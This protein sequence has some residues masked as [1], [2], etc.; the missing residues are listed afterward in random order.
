MPKIKFDI[1]IPIF[2]GAVPN[3]SY[4]EYSKIK[5][6]CKV[7][8]EFGY[9]T[10]W[11]ADHLTMGEDHRIWE[12]WTILSSLVNVTNL[13]LGTAML[14]VVHRNPALL[15][16]MAATFD[17][18]TEGR[19][20]FGLGAG[21]RESEVREYGIPWSKSPKE[22]VEMLEE[23]L[24]IAK[25]MWTKDAPSFHG[26]H[27][28]IEHAWCEPKPIQKPHPPIWIGG[29]GEKLLLKLVARHADGWDIPATTTQV[30]AHKAK[31]LEQYCREEQRDF[32]RIER[33]IDTNIII[34]DDPDIGRKVA[35]WYDWLRHVQSEIGSL[36]PPLNVE[37]VFI[38]G[39]VEK[40]VRRIEEYVNAGVE[41]F[42]FYFFDYP[43]LYSAKRIGKEV[44]PSFS[45]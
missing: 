13:R 42:K 22:R 44:I 30:Y 28:S 1:T 18:I 31:L 36:K 21:W 2:A 39:S 8:E 34:S 45:R 12:C 33:S 19:L 15:A 43:D 32:A 4:L 10:L 5:E 14:N 6:L 20:N 40:C 38:F 29:G 35:E 27:F 41:R 24:T 16:K 9:D 11:V 25:L 7:G 37:D 17:L 26:K 23:A 3:R